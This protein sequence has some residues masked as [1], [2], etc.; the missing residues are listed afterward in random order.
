M[1]VILAIIQIPSNPIS[2]GIFGASAPVQGSGYPS[3]SMLGCQFA[4]HVSALW[5]S[6]ELES[7]QSLSRGKSGKKEFG[8]RSPYSQEDAAGLSPAYMGLHADDQ[9]AVS[10]PNLAR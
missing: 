5:E 8:Q 2:G 10:R 9:S 6:G 3:S 1:T 7:F 4:S